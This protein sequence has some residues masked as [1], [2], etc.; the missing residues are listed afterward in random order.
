LEIQENGRELSKNSTDVEVLNEK[1]N[2]KDWKAEW[3]RSL[4]FSLHFHV[5]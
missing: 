4:Q 5:G 2:V 3:L 1:A